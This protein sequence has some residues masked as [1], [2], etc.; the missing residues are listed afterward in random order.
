L[1]RE[2]SRALPGGRHA[3]GASSKRIASIASSAATPAAGLQQ[4]ACADLPGAETIFT[5]IERIGER[6]ADAD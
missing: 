4:V 6:F 2:C 3:P 5:A 1:A